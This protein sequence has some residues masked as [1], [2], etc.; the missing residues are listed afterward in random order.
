[1]QNTGAHKDRN[2]FG[3]WNTGIQRVAHDRMPNV[4]ENVYQYP[5]PP[6]FLYRI[7]G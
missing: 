1:M 6:M 2:Y 7:W 5:K 4:K 3:L